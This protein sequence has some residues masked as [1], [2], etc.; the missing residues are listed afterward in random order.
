[1]QIC[2][3]PWLNS[4]KIT[5]KMWLRW[6]HQLWLKQ[7]KYCFHIKITWWIFVFRLHSFH[8]FF[9]F[10]FWTWLS[11][12]VKKNPREILRAWLVSKNIWTA[13]WSLFCCNHYHFFQIWSRPLIMV[14]YFWTMWLSII[15]S[16]WIYLFP[17]ITRI[18]RM[19][20]WQIG[21]FQSVTLLSMNCIQNLD[22]IFQMYR[23]Q[24]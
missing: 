18:W 13:K 4:W 16:T 7:M 1:M 17:K 14:K 3:R 20:Y 9:D 19:N 2:W 8:C 5:L 15:D 21:S 22:F 24:W 10:G 6:H 23:Y 11:K 12:M